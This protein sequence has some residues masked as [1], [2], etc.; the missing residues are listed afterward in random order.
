MGTTGRIATSKSRLGDLA[1]MW[2][3]FLATW[4]G[5]EVFPNLNSTGP[6]DLL[7]KINGQIYEF[8]VK[9]EVW[10][11]QKN[12]YVAKNVSVVKP[13][14]FPISVKPEG[15]ICDWKVRWIRGKEPA[16]LENFWSR[17]HTFYPLNA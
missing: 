10:C 17:E 1:E 11:H 14:V 7:M 8:D 12:M 16:G 2:V 6:A 9:C 3:G 13:P 4:K 15:D 5:A